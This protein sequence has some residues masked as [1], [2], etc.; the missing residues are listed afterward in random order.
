MIGHRLTLGAAGVDVGGSVPS[1]T[2]LFAGG[3]ATARSN[4]IDTIDIAT[5]GNATDFGDLTVAR[6]NLS[7]ASNGANNRAVFAGGSDATH[8]NNM[9]DYVSMASAGNAVDFGDLAQPAQSLGGTSNGTNGRA[10]FGGGAMINPPYFSQLEY[11][12]ISTTGNAATFGNL[13]ATRSNLAATSNAT[14]NRGVFSGGMYSS[15]MN[16]IDYITIST[17]GN[18][19]D[20][21]DLTTVTQQHAALSSGENN[22]GIFGGGSPSNK[23][24]TSYINISS[25]GNATAC[26]GGLTVGR[27]RVSGTSNGVGNRGVFG[28]GTTGTAVSNV[29]DYLTINTA[30]T[31]QDFG[32][33][34]VAR[35]GVGAT[36]NA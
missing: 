30:S 15:D 5:T 34:T 36:S 17:T 35:Y 23:T 24:L 4:V 14:N 16:V 11:I 28:G 33:L 6:L 29:L 27:S 1:A 12:T 18:A 8:T 32:D 22:R 26:S 9:I 25:T 10:V 19:I 3:Y 13:S 20:F 2:A 21:G 31:T 7:A